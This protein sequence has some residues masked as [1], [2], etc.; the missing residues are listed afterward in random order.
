MSNDGI[1]DQATFWARSDARL[2]IDPST[3]VTRRTK[4]PAAFPC[5]M[6]GEM[7]ALDRWPKH[8]QDV[9]CDTCKDATRVFLD[10][11]EERKVAEEYRRSQ[12]ESKN[13]RY[14]GLPELSDEDKEALSEMRT[15][16]S[17]MGNGRVGNRRR[18]GGGGGGA[19]GD[20]RRKRRSRGRGDEAK[21]DNPQQEPREGEDGGGR[22]R[23]A[24]L[25][26]V[27]G[28]ED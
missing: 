8:R 3:N 15:R 1:E 24:E 12:K 13:G 21:P 14:R 7:C 22:K 25:L 10:D 26:G 17:T 2:G 20:G 18:G 4:A 11:A 23:L 16:A 5:A 28:Q 6:C 19:G 27:L 9:I